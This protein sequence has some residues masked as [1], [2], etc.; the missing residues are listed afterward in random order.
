LPTTPLRTNSIHLHLHVILAVCQCL[1]SHF[2]AFATVKFI[3]SIR[4]DSLWI[5]DDNWN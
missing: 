3:F 4:S 1:R 2:S 5:W